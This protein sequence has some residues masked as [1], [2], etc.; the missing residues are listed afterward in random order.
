I[1]GVAE[2]IAV[3][4]VLVNEVEG[5]G[6]PFVFELGDEVEWDFTKTNK[7]DIAWLDTSSAY[8][9]LKYYYLTDYIYRYFG[10]VDDDWLTLKGIIS[11]ITVICVTYGPHPRKKLTLIPL[12]G[13]TWNLKSAIYRDNHFIRARLRSDKRLWVDAYRVEIENPE[14]KPVPPEEWDPEFVKY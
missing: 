6:V 7:E 11:K 12:S 3:V 5:D 9:N 4:T 1:C 8:K 13:F 10:P 14:I 2:G